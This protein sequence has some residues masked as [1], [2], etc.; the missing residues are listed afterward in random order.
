MHHLQRAIIDELGVQPQ[1]DPVQEVD[2][3]TD[4]LAEYAK[5]AGAQGFVLGVSGGV[6]STLAGILAQ[7]AAEQLRAQGYEASFHALRLPHGVQHDEDDA[8]EALSF[9]GPD[10][11]HTM[12]IEDAVT[13]MDRAFHE[14]FGRRLADYHRGNVKA[15]MRMIAQ[16]AV[17]AEHSALVVGTD[18]GAEAVT[19]FF[20]KHGDG[21]ADV[22]PNFT[23]NKRQVRL[24]LQH[25]GAPERLWAK[26]PTADLLDENPGQLDEVEMGISYEQIDDYLEG[27][28]IDP[29]A[30]AH[31]EKLYHRSRHK[32]TT[33]PTL[34]DDWWK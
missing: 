17:A 26:P 34:L 31:L 14:G 13:G 21:G 19:G 16:Y 24:V 18:H 28:E 30:A 12:N 15:R 25:V 22:Q 20:T 5:S 33:A 8:A 7:K 2:R 1:I 4:F 23:L 10:H 9:I 27:R 32:R 29:G 3:R 11:T 6:D